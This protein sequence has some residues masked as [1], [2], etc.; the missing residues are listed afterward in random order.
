[1]RIRVSEPELAR[2]LLDV[3]RLRSDCLVSQVNDRELEARLIGSYADSGACE[4]TLIVRGW[5]AA[6]PDVQV[7]LG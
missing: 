7:E 1:M 4:L 5:Q 3:L 2:D 6:H